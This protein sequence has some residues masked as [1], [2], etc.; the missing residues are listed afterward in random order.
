MAKKF[1]QKSKHFFPTATLFHFRWN[2]EDDFFWGGWGGGEQ[3]KGFVTKKVKG[4][5]S[6][7]IER[8][9]F[10]LFSEQKPY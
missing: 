9:S 2:S 10:Q 4:T 3:L 7:L 1:L 8:V 6:D 5:H